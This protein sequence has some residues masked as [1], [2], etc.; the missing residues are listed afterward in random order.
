MFRFIHQAAKGNEVLEK[1]NPNYPHTKNS[2]EGLEGVQKRFVAFNGGVDEPQMGWLRMSL[3]EAKREEQRVIIISH[4]PILPESSSPVCLTWNY[5]EVLGLLREYKCTV[6]ASFSGHAHRDGYK[7]DDVSGIHFRV[8]EA[9]LESN[10]PVKTYAF[11][12]V[13][14]DRLEIRGEGD[15]TSAIYDLNHLSATGDNWQAKNRTW[16]F[17]TIQPRLKSA[18]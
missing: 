16:T 11:F 6:A 4:Q 1:H 7:R 9:A 5:D 3:E 17:S 18:L 12:D 14:V 8:F 13:H 2:P 15:C 10:D